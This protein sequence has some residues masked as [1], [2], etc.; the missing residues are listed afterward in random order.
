MPDD[1]AIILNTKNLSVHPLIGF[2]TPGGD[3]ATAQADT[4]N[5][6]EFVYDTL[7]QVGTFFVNSNRDMTILT[8]IT[9]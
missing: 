6:Q 3:K 9:Y 4:R 7:A 1:K 5:D 8:G 2:T